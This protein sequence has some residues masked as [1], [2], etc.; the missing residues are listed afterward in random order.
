LIE[1]VLDNNH[2]LLFPDTMSGLTMK[3]GD[4]TLETGDVIVEVGDLSV[5]SS[6][7]FLVGGTTLLD[8]IITDISTNATDISTNATNIS[9]NAESITTNAT[10]IAT[11]ATN[12]ATNA[13][14]IA[15][16]A[17]SISTINT[18]IASIEDEINGLATVG[19]NTDPPVITQSS[20]SSETDNFT[21]VFEAA[22]VSQS[23]LGFGGY[24]LPAVD[25]LYITVSEVE[26]TESDVTFTLTDTDI[27]L[28]TSLVCQCTSTGS[29]ASAAVSFSGT[30]ITLASL[31]TSS[32]YNITMYFANETD[33]TE[34]TLLEDDSGGNSLAVQ[35]AGVPSAPTSIVAVSTADYGSDLQ[36]TLVIGYYS[37]ID[38]E[39]TDY[40][41]AVLDTATITI[42]EETSTQAAE[43]RNYTGGTI[44]VARDDWTN[45][46]TQTYTMT[47]DTVGIDTTSAF[48]AGSTYTLSATVENVLQSG[49]SESYTSE[50][51]VL[52]TD[53]YN[54]SNVVPDISTE[55]QNLSNFSTGK[56]FYF[57]DNTTSSITTSTTLHLLPVAPGSYTESNLTS[58][59]AYPGDTN[60][61]ADMTT[62]TVSLQ[63][64]NGS[65]LSSLHSENLTLT[66]DSVSND[67][68]TTPVMSGALVSNTHGYYSEYDLTIDFDNILA[69]SPFIPSEDGGALI[70]L[71]NT[72]QSI[73]W[74]LNTT[75]SVDTSGTDTVE[76]S[77][78]Q[79]IHCD[80]QSGTCAVSAPTITLTGFVATYICGVPS[81]DKESY[82][83]FDIDADV[84]DCGAW[85]PSTLGTFKV[86]TTEGGDAL[87]SESVN[88]EDNWTPSSTTDL[89]GNVF[90]T[91]NSSVIIDDSIDY[92][93]SVYAFVYFYP[94]NKTSYV[95]S[96]NTTLSGLH[97]D[98]ESLYVDGFEY[99]ESNGNYTRRVDISNASAISLDGSVTYNIG[100][101]VED[102]DFASYDHTA[103]VA[104]TE[105]LVLF[106]GVLAGNGDSTWQQDF[107]STSGICSELIGSYP[108][109]D[110]TDVTSTTRWAVFTWPML[111]LNSV[112]LWNIYLNDVSNSSDSYLVYWKIVAYTSSD[113]LSTVD[114]NSKWY[115]ATRLFGSFNE[116]SDNGTAEGAG[117][118]TS[119]G[120]T[121]SGTTLDLEITHTITDG[122]DY[123][124]YVAVGIPAGSAFTFSSPDVMATY[125]NGDTIMFSTQS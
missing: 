118:A 81:I 69:A 65:D 52:V 10:D 93:S 103:S 77:S 8:T 87:I 120:T 89:A 18:D 70:T 32:S 76:T 40:T 73:V 66:W 9:T 54:Y 50:A 111:T 112:S 95:S 75:Y 41:N 17:T 83:T 25:T 97:Y 100:V 104:Y 107:T 67:E 42:E 116:D 99:D 92:F 16:N 108:S 71:T 102:A 119:N 11:N 123:Y 45:T 33:V 19:I 26:A 14:D 48:R 63:I 51:S 101:D 29:I 21:I 37:A 20:Y 88:P 86:K 30:T 121:L 38:A 79:T 84:S 125:N 28:A 110:Y 91:D 6:D 68:A 106:K 46:D 114:Y 122:E 80:M 94:G 61:A 98:I 22:S 44:E 56:V 58:A 78:Q 124:V 72:L 47:L 109:F 34:S 1:Q 85:L 31:S 60:V 62:A 59:M 5:A 53:V 117:I 15:T 27:N 115:D 7:K 3:T 13:T 113:V 90:V 35:V 64:L 55:L 39:L 43:T 36:M 57:W 96:S 4:I 49:S 105:D 24:V 12:I 82:L 2:E 74:S 23:S